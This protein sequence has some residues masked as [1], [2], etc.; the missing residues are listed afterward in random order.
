MGTHSADILQADHF[1][2]L[3]I[4]DLKKLAFCGRFTFEA[5]LVGLVSKQDV[6]HL[7]LVAHLLFP[8]ADDA[9]F[10]GDAGLGHNNSLCLGVACS[11][12]SGGYHRR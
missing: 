5:G 12:G 8:A 9:A 4:E 10:H 11:S 7:D 3:F 6:A 2:T 1:L